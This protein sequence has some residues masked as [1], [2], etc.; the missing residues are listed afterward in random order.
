MPS[1]NILL[2]LSYRGGNGLPLSIESV[3]ISIST[4]FSPDMLSKTLYSMPNR[5]LRY[6]AGVSICSPIA[7]VNAECPML[8]MSSIFVPPTA[9]GDNPCL[10][11]SRAERS[12]SIEGNQ[13]KRFNY[14]PQL[15]DIRR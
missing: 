2:C 15:R 12:G 6:F 7:K 4:S 13:S 14:F 3:S 10:L 1:I 8:L 11:P 9:S 5:S